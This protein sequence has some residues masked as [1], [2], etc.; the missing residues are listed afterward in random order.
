MTSSFIV[1]SNC[2]TAGSQKYH[3][4][5]ELAVINKEID[6]PGPKYIT[7]KGNKN[8]KRHTFV[9]I[10]MLRL[11]PTSRSYRRLGHNYISLFGHFSSRH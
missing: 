3:V 2:C 10:L 8:C 6:F 4:D 1:S 7:D 5:E 9:C 11:K